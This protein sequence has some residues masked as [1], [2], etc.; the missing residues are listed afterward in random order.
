MVAAIV[1]GGITVKAGALDPGGDRVTVSPAAA[2]QLAESAA[3]Y[4][5]VTVKL[6]GLGSY[7]VAAAPGHRVGNTVVVGSACGRFSRPLPGWH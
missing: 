5:P 4:G 3:T 6:D 2:R 7:R 1:S